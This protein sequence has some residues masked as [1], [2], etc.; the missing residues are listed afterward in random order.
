MTKKRSLIFIGIAVVAFGAVIFALREPDP[1]VV[2]RRAQVKLT[3]EKTMRVEAAVSMAGAPKE[4]GGTFTENATGVDI[5][6]R[7]DLDRSDPLKP[8]SVSTFAFTQT[9]GGQPARISGEARR[10]DGAYYLHLDAA[11]GMG[12]GADKLVGVWAKSA[13]PLTELLVP[14]SEAAKTERP[15]D[16]AGI[17]TLRLALTKVDLL[18]AVKKLPAEKVGDQDAYH[19]VV[20]TDLQTVSALLL[21]RRE[22]QSPEP[23]AAAD[24]LAVTAEI[25]Q[26]GKPIGEVWI[27]KHDG[28]LLKLS[29]QT[30]FGDVSGAATVQAE[31][32]RYGQPVTVTAPEAQ[33]LESLLGMRSDEHLSLAGGRTVTTSATGAS[34]ATPPPGPGMEAYVNDSDEDGLVD[35]QEYF[36]GSD[37]WNPDTD[38]DGW[39]DGYEVDKGL[40]PIG[41]GTLF[42][43]GL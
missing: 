40:N 2:L 23:L 38:G 12:S 35:G 32:S 30:T 42:G 24:V 33:D 25:V 5:A 11:E 7:A 37:A 1:Q 29:L 19:Y 36:Y 16:A 15:L 9:G 17:Q 34:S 14:P 28:R 4:L 43:F 6:I 18:K 8:A 22:L 26:W 27:G 41:P 39:K 20:E 21:K 10:K 31:F 13:R 3:N